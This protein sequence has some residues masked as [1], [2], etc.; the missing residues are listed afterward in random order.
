MVNRLW[1][2]LMGR[3]IV[4]NV[5]DWEKSDPSHP[6]LLEWLGHRLVESGYDLKAVTKLILTS[7]A[8]QRAVD[9][10]L[11]ATSPLYIAQAPR[12]LTAEQIVDSLFSA[13]GAPFELEEVSLD[14]DSVRALE[15]SITLGKPERAW[16]L[17]STSN[18]RDRPS[19]SLPRIQAVASIM[20]TFGWRG[21]RQDPI[22]IRS[23]DPNVLQPAI[24]ANG[25]M[26]TW[27]TRLSDRSRADRVS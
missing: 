13:T 6:E 11:K 3:G 16:M 21:A 26:G 1:Q 20:E 2:R 17:A 25:V 12:R 7:H 19:L 4:E 27:L 18:E 8:Y 23:V 14:I 15:S 5:A 22:S 24:L 9:P 10:M